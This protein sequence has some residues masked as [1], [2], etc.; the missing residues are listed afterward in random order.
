M[1]TRIKCSEVVSCSELFDI[2]IERYNVNDIIKNA[3]KLVLNLDKKS[4]RPA[5]ET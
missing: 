3:I 1:A 5:D 2:I 4:L